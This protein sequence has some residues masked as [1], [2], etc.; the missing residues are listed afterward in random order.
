MRPAGPASITKI[1]QKQLWPQCFSVSKSF[2]SRRSS[3]DGRGVRVG[4][5]GGRNDVDRMSFLWPPQSVSQRC[6][7]HTFFSLSEGEPQADAC[8]S[9]SSQGELMATAP[10]SLPL[11]Q[12]G[13]NN[14]AVTVTTDEAPVL[15]HNHSFYWEK[16]TTHCFPSWSYSAVFVIESASVLFNV[17]Q[18]VT[19][20][21]LV[22][23]M[24]PNK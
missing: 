24:D 14:N 18:S 19:Q 13:R 3:R 22:L 21:K 20:K 6:E 7:S 10:A 5:G 16:R 4:G 11:H 17:L 12:T 1:I 9:L 15:V 23:H 8:M 2:Y